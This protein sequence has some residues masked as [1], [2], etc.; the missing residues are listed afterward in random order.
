MSDRGTCWS[1]TINNPTKSD[2][3]WIAQARLNRGWK[4][5]GQLEKGAQGTEHYQ[6]MVTTP[7]VRFSAIK[8][9]FPRAHIELARDKNAL[10][11]YVSKEDTRL[12]QL[13]S[14]PEFV[15]P[16]KLM[17]WYGEYYDQVVSLHG[18][19]RLPLLD[20]FDTMIK[21]K[22]M[23]GFYV[24]S[25]GANPQIRAQI[26]QY[27]KAIAFRERLLRR[28]KDR[29]TTENILPQEDIT[30]DGSLSST[31]RSRSPSQDGYDSSTSSS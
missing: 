26:K 1:V 17:S 9:A 19:D 22:I 3:E 13:P 5:Y 18:E 14:S 27:G 15:T 12:G 16:N 11:K 10:A 20:I 28:Q 8:K 30:Q 29:Q 21:Q 24:E 6:L 7:Q 31:P 2:E 23:E 25:Y 4:V